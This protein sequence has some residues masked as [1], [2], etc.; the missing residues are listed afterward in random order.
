MVEEKIYVADE[1][2]EGIKRKEEEK[3]K[4]KEKYHVTMAKEMHD[5]NEM[6]EMV[7]RFEK[8]MDEKKEKIDHLREL[9]EKNPE[10]KSILWRMDTNLL[11]TESLFALG[12]LQNKVM[13][14]KRQSNKKKKVIQRYK[15]LYLFHSRECETSSS[16]INE[17]ESCSVILNDLEIEDL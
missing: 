17:E 14:L 15:I 8:E 1:V 6:K 13:K 10:R 16:K 7:K 3:E 11:V 5:L 4:M 2:L 12:K 9:L